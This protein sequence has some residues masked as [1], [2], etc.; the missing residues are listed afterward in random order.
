MVDWRTGL[1]PLNHPYRAF[2][3][4][5]GGCTG[6]VQLSAKDKISD[7]SDVVICGFSGQGLSSERV[8]GKPARLI[9]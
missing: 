9:E 2:L 3:M 6:V 7:M 8:F 4:M 1:P 5:P